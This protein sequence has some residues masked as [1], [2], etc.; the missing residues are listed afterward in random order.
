M[1]SLLTRQRRLKRNLGCLIILHAIAIA[2][3][4]AFACLGGWAT[5]A[6]VGA[7]IPPVY[8]QLT[9]IEVYDGDTIKATIHLGYDVALTKRSIRLLGTDTWEITKRR[10]TVVVTDEEI[11]K[12]IVARDALKALLDRHKGRVYLRLSPGK[13]DPHGRVPGYLWVF[14]RDTDPIDIAKWNADHGHNRSDP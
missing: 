8:Y 10:R 14:P 7:D 13:R 5:K 1:T 9:D 4:I 11:A 12:G 2:L 3:L 6:V